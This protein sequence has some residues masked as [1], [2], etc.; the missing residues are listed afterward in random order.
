MKPSRVSAVCFGNFIL[1]D[2]PL[3]EFDVRTR[4]AIRVAASFHHS[5]RPGERYR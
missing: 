2:D 5:V 4:H 1:V 3:P